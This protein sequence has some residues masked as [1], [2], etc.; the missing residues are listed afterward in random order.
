V[1]M[2]PPSKGMYIYVRGSTY[3]L[4]ALLGLAL[5]LPVL[6]LATR[7]L[8][9]VAALQLQGTRAAVD[10]LKFDTQRP[11]TSSFRS[12]EPGSTVDLCL[13]EVVVS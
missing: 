7:R 9:R 1:S 6:R 4:D 13:A 12:R 10:F 11:T 5:L 8:E 3:Q 2:G